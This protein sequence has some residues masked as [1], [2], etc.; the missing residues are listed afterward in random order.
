[1]RTTDCILADHSR[2][3]P[4]RALKQV[5]HRQEDYF[6]YT[7]KETELTEIDNTRRINDGLWPTPKYHFGLAESM[8]RKTSPLTWPVP[9]QQHYCPDRTHCTTCAGSYRESVSGSDT[10]EGKRRTYLS[11]R[12]ANGPVGAG[13]SMPMKLLMQEPWTS[14]M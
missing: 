10:D 8:Y 5:F 3:T 12:I 6:L 9:R 14:R 7:S 13:K 4:G 1:M 11:P 2:S